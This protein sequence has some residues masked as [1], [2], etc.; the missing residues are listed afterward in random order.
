M[1][2]ALSAALLLTGLSAAAAD[3]GKDPSGTGALL[4]VGI[5]QVRA[6]RAVFEG[7]RL[8]PDDLAADQPCF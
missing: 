3:T 1:R 5:L 8:E 2:L 4:R 6:R 7:R